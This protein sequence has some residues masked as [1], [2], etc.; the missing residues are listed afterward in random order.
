MKISKKNN[1]ILLFLYFLIMI[2]TSLAELSF[3]PHLWVYSKYV[4]FLEFLILGFLLSLYFYEKLD[5]LFFFIIFFCLIVLS[6]FDEG[7]Q[8]FSATR[9][10]TLNDFS[11]NI[12]GGFTSLIIIYI[13][14]KIKNG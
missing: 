7:I 14:K 13:Y 11:I 2:F 9:T 8:V 5:S 4:H 6:V 1:F 3:S 12:L 10:L